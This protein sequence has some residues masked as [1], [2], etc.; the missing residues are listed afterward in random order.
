MNYLLRGASPEQIA[1]CFTDGHGE[2]ECAAEIQALLDARLKTERER[3]AQ[4]CS[5]YF[6]V[7]GSADAQLLAELIREAP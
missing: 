3:C 6:K 5:G 2:A 1:A 7:T 4:I